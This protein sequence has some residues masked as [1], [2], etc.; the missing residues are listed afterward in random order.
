MGLHAFVRTRAARALLLAVGVTLPAQRSAAQES[1]GSVVGAA[2][3]E[4]IWSDVE[5]EVRLRR[6]D[7]DALQLLRDYGLNKDI[8]KPRRG[9]NGSIVFPFGCYAGS[10]HLCAASRL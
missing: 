2:R 7:K 5:E 4:A 1:S 6:H 10:H 9:E 3:L 8:D